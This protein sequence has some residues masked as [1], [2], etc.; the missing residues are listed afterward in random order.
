MADDSKAE[1]MPHLT[2]A[3]C[4]PKWGTSICFA[5]LWISFLCFFKAVDCSNSSFPS[6]S[7]RLLSKSLQTAAG[8]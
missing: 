6:K 3:E 8:T 7:S 5:V 4:K 1:M 2:M